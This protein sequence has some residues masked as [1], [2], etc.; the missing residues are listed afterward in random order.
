[1]FVNP[2]HTP[3]DGHGGLAAKAC[4][5]LA[6]R[7]FPCFRFDLPGLGDT[8]GVLPEVTSTLYTFV[9]DGGFASMATELARKIHDRYKLEG[10][11]MGGLCGAAVTGIYVADLDPDVIRALILLE[12]ELYSGG[13]APPPQGGQDPQKPAG[14]IAKAK[15]KVFSYWGWTLMLTGESPYARYVP[16]PREQI[17][18]FLM[19]SRELPRITNAVLVEAWQ[20]VR[21][22]RTPTLVVTAKGKLREHFFDRINH[23]ALE[24]IG[25][26]RMDHVRLEGTNHIFTTGGAIDRVIQLLEDWSERAL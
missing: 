26:A 3:R 4:D 20:R 5:R 18:N 11:V 25:M 1:L 23:I 12:P 19:T 16:L 6:A 17:Y 9:A 7:G 2:G 10:I 24:R 15:S 8:K 21:V 14:L 22:R 13:Y